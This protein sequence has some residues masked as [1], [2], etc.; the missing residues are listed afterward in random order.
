MEFCNGHEYHMTVPLCALGMGADSSRQAGVLA[1]CGSASLGPG[2]SGQQELWRGSGSH[3]GETSSLKYLLH[4]A[5][6]PWTLESSG[7]VGGG[8]EERRREFQVLCK[9]IALHFYVLY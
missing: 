8:R 7:F 6:C 5:L 1:C 4:Y 3:E 9:D 2:G